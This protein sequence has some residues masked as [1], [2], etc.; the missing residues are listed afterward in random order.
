MENYK[1]VTFGSILFSFIFA[2]LSL[3]DI[4]DSC[5]KVS[6]KQ[7]EE[8]LIRWALKKTGLK[9]ESSPEGKRIER[10]VIV[11][12]NI[13]AKSDPWP[14]FLNMFHTKTRDRVIRQ[15]ILLKKGQEWNKALVAE[16]E[17][18][19]R[20]LSILAVA[21]VVTCRS[22]K[23]DHVVLLVVTKD[24]WS[25]RLNFGY[26]L[27]GLLFSSILLAPSEGNL[28]GLNKQVYLGL[29][30]SQFDLGT[31]T[32]HNRFTFS[33]SYYDGRL[34]GTRWQLY[35]QGSLSVDGTVPCG[36]SIGEKRDIWCSKRSP[37][38]ISSGTLNLT[39]TRPLYALSAKWGFSIQG[40]LSAGEARS[41]VQNRSDKEP[42]P[43]EQ[44]GVSLRTVR[45]RH[46]DGLLRAIPRVFD[47][48][49][50]GASFSFTRSYGDVTKHDVSGGAGFYS[51]NRKPIDD[52]PFDD[53][54]RRWFIRNVLSRSETAIYSFFSYRMRPTKFVRLRNIQTFA[55]SED[56]SVGLN[57]SA[58][59]RLALDLYHWGQIFSLLTGRIS[60]RWYVW[61]HLL[62]IGV[63]AGSRWQPHLNELGY[64]GPWA[65]TS[66]SSWISHV[67]PHFWGGRIH[68][69]VS[70]FLRDNNLENSFSSLGASTG[71]RGYPNGAFPGK[72]YFSANV[73]YR[74]L[75]ITILTT[76]VGGVLFYDGGAVFGGNDPNE[77]EK[78]LAFQY[79]HSVGIGFRILFP[80]F[81]RSV[82]RVDMGIPLSEGAGQFFT[83]FSLTTGQVF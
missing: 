62:S 27:N 9:R 83:W 45:F 80:Q 2:L 4:Q 40:Y 77:P 72:N 26:S 48:N 33:E 10:I 75:P 65:N 22:K 29:S 61:D 34:L 3:G 66:F 59:I 16:T 49:D 53:Q 31:F 12:E 19:L 63:N 47:T 70:V 15:E 52:F 25:L 56:Y 7:Y 67:A 69:Q 5:A 58:S 50:F 38:S 1:T 41:F 43:G 46:P 24:L 68:S 30:M 39:I 11:R 28:F 13:I 35:Q 21:R 55:F 74:T 60:Y 8:K 18:N 23:P 44:R 36:G 51:Q 82:F 32:L 6:R 79:K 78:P 57:V 71:L 20:V 64:K 37:G 76:H 81:N 73:E 42:P 14:M 17:R 54:T